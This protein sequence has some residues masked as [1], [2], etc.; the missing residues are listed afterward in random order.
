[1]DHW[2]ISLIGV[3]GLYLIASSASAAFLAC[4]LI[5]F[6]GLVGL[7][8]HRLFCERLATAVNKATKIM[9]LNYTASHGVAALRISASEIVNA[10]TAYYAASLLHV[11][12]FVR[13]KMCWW[14]ALAKKKMWFWIASFGDPYNGDVLQYTKQLFLT[15]LP[16]MTKYFVMRECEHMGDTSI[17]SQEGFFF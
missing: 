13:E 8:S 17:W 15:R 9:W 11:C 14:L 7:L 6:V 10:A 12:T 3:L 1:L 5:S 2:P 4:Q 16:Q